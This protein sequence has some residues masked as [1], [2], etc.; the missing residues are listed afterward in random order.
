MFL[1]WPAAFPGL[2]Q[3]PFL[4][5]KSSITSL[6]ADD[7]SIYLCSKDLSQHNKNIN[8]DLDKLDDLLKGNKLS[9]NVAKTHSMPIASQRKHNSLRCS[10]IRFHTKIGGK[11]I[12]IRNE[13]KYLGV[14]IDETLNWKEHISFG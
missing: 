3:C 9:L 14:Q 2:H 12:E 5:I 11:E 4:A 10:N 1:P 7:T 6:N 13:I 8:D